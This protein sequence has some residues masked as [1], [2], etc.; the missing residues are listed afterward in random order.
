LTA[1]VAKALKPSPDV[2]LS[3]HRI[4]LD[5]SRAPDGKYRLVTTN[6]DLLFE[7]CDSSL[8]FCCPPRL[9]DPHRYDEFEGIIHLHGHVDNEYQGAAGDG[10]VLS[11][12][13]F[14]RAYLSDGWA[15]QFIKA[16]LD[17][18]FV[19]FI[20]YAADD[21]PVLYLLEAL[22]RHFGSLEGVYAFQSGSQS[23]AEAKWRHKGVQP[24]A[25]D[26]A[27]EHRILWE[28]LAAWATRAQ[29][30]IAWQ[31]EVICQARK[32]P[33]A[34]LPHQRGQ[35]A[36]IVSTLEGVRKFCCSTDPPPAEWLCVFDST[37]RYSKPGHIWVLNEKGRYFDPFEAY[38]LDSD[39][40]PSPIDPDDIWA[41][42]ELPQDAWNAFTAT[43]LDRQKLEDNN[44][45][46][47]RGHLSVNL[48]SMPPRLWQLGL[49]LG[50][51]AH[52]PAAVWWGANQVGIHPE[53]QNRIIYELERKK[54]VSSPEIRLAWR[55]IFDAWETRRNDFRRDWYELKGSIAVN[56]WTSPAIRE[57]A[58]IYRPYLKVGRPYGRGP[59]P[60]E[61]GADTHLRDMVQLDVEYPESVEEVHI[62]DEFLLTTVR[63]VRKNLEYAVTL[64][65]ELGGYGLHHLC[66]IERD[67]GLQGEESER[68]YGISRFFFFYFRLVERLA[69]IDVRATKE[70]YLAW[71]SDDE[72]IFARLRIWASGQGKLL[73]GAEAGRVICHLTENTFWNSR[74][75]R[76]LLLTIK[77]RWNDFPKL[78]KK[79][80]GQRSIFHFSIKLRIARFQP[81]SC[82]SSQKT[83]GGVNSRPVM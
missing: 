42:R 74:H 49:W 60:P 79:Y 27:G 57:L 31:D 70:E 51:I 65:R 13:E 72:T 16:I 33:E 44:F 36:H 68:N 39:Q 54:K 48:P 10:F 46:A 21:P 81:S 3:A 41:K 76:D 22:N 55:Y 7:S 2:D 64:E 47:F 63:E 73:T 58:Q 1:A 32:G 26:D 40:I 77:Q 66:P 6:F 78:R 82:T 24:I 15:T 28:T 5:L 61:D 12:S 59:R 20:G 53:I 25:Y 14:G 43:R 45:A 8:R 4:M 75:Q 34:M 18:Y 62:P 37:I 56:G 23:E 67:P 30:P 83:R 71:W 35:V 17:N 19:V 50:E 11:S 80:K 52:Q 69:A 9:P 38:G 29:D